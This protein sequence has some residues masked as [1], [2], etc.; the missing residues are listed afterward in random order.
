MGN[1]PS[2]YT[3]Y[4]VDYSTPAFA[5]DYQYQP[6]PVSES[7]M[8]YLRPAT[9]LAQYIAT[10]PQAVQQYIQGWGESGSGAL[11]PGPPMGRYAGDKYGWADTLDAIKSFAYN[12]AMD[13]LAAK[14]GGLW[15]PRRGWIKE[16]GY[17]WNV[18][19]YR[20]FKGGG[21]TGSGEDTGGGRGG[22][23]ETES[24]PSGGRGGV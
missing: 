12:T 16:H 24:D 23:T 18:R 9:P 22:A 6:A 7:N 13:A 10:Q 19:G 21:Y 3:P 11:Q 2:E 1:G 17:G 20:A 4:N 8:N 14:T 15:D 5:Q